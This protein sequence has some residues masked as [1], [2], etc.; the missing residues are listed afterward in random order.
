[1]K[2]V[3]YFYLKTEKTF[4]P[5]QYSH[6]HTKDNIVQSVGEAGEQLSH[7]VGGWLNGKPL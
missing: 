2:N 6:I 7:T 1:M 4:W 3:L 5:T